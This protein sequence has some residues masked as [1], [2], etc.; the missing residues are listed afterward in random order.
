MKHQIYYYNSPN[1]KIY[2]SQNLASAR[3]LRYN[4]EHI[5][6]R[7]YSSKKR[8]ACDLSENGKKRAKEGKIFED[9]GKNVQN[10]N[11]F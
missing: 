3:L 9:F 8:H 6:C 4:N 2:I 5:I 11:I 10:L 7:A 1:Y